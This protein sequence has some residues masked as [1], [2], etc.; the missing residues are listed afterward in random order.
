M[1]E[2]ILCNKC[3][4][5]CNLLEHLYP[6]DT[7]YYSGLIKAKVIGGYNSTPGNGFGALCDNSLYT[8]S[9]CEFCLDE[10][11]ETFKIP[12]EERDNCDGSIV[13]WKSATEKVKTESWRDYNPEYFLEESKK[14]RSE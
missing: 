7:P 1:S 6:N 4:N 2:R 5:T 10:L 3:G 14:R 13:E 12:V 11:F 9:L 8:F